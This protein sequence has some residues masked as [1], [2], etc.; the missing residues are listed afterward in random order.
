MKIVYKWSKVEILAL[1]SIFVALAAWLLPNPLD[2]PRDIDNS[3]SLQDYDEPTDNLFNDNLSANLLEQSTGASPIS[4]KIPYE[5]PIGSAFGVGWTAP[6]TD[7][8]YFVLVPASAPDTQNGMAVYAAKA[9]NP[10]IFNTPSS[11]G[12]YQI[13]F[14]T[15]DGEVLAR[16]EFTVT[17]P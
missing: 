16:K 2:L 1:V 3:A 7:N 13:R 5:V 14:K 4:I 9:R 8:N 15:S 10:I 11:P 17:K 12:K 6:T